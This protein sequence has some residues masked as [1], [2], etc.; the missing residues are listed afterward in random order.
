MAKASNGDASSFDG[1]GSVWFKVY[2]MT[3]VA[4]GQTITFPSD[5]KCPKYTVELVYQLVHAY[6]SHDYRQLP[7]SQEL[8]IWTVPRPH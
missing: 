7:N 2:Q 5:S 6:T 3:A 4:N 8:A 1:S